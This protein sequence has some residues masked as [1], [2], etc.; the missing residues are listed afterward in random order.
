MHNVHSL[1][2]L[3]LHVRARAHTVVFTVL[4]LGVPY[5]RNVSSFSSLGHVWDDGVYVN[6]QF[7]CF[8]TTISQT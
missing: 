1:L 6:L 8:L 7:C 2:E 3:L 4:F 5:L